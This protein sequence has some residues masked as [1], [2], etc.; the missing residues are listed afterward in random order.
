VESNG[1]SQHLLQH[2]VQFSE[3]RFVEARAELRGVNLSPP[4]G[5][6]RVDIANT[7]DDTLIQQQ[8]LDPRSAGQDP[9]DE[10]IDG[11]L[12]RVGAKTLKLSLQHGTGKVRHPPESAR[13]NVA[14]LAS[15]I[16]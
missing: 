7:A 14:Q 4:Q 2:A 10:I 9:L 1:L 3:F 8:S 6:I 5:L 12:E 15:I 13:I 11:C 16:Q